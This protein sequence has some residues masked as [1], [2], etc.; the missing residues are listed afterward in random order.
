MYAIIKAGG[1]QYRVTQN[2]VIAVNRLAANEGDEIVI[3]EVML[4]SDD[5]GVNIGSPYVTGAKVVGKVMKHYKGRKINGFT[6]K[7]KKD[8]H[9]RYGHRQYLTRVAITDIKG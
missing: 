7:P 6:Y 2:D 5:K 3:N 8:E 9:R 1:K 4:V